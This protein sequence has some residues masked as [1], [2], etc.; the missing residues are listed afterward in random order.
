MPAFTRALALLAFALPLPAQVVINEFVYDDTGVDNREFVEL[1]NA[2]P[3][4]VDISGW[5]LEG[6]DN[7]WTAPLT[8]DN[9][10]DYTIPP[11]T[12]LMPGAF[13]VIGAPTVPNVHLVVGTQDLWENDKE[14]LVLR[15]PGPAFTIVDAVGYEMNLGTALNPSLYEGPGI[16]GN[17]Q[18]IDNVPSSWSR[19]TDGHDT[20]DNGADFGL[21]PIT[22]GASNGFP[23]IVPWCDDFEGR[24]VETT[25]ND[26]HA[27]F[28][29]PVI[30]DPTAPGQ[31]L[32]VPRPP[33]PDGGLCG[34]F[35]DPAGGGNGNTLSTA[36]AV[37]WTV[38]CYVYVRTGIA[39]PGE[40]ETWSIGV[41]GT[42]DP[43]HNTSIDGATLN[44]TITTVNQN[45][46]V[47]WSYITGPALSALH[48][49]DEGSGGPQV[50]LATIPVLPGVNDGWQRLRL[51]VS[52]PAITAHFGGT[53]GDPT[54]GQVFNFA[55]PTTHPGVPYFGYREF[56]NPGV[57]NAQGLLVDRLRITS[58]GAPCVGAFQRNQPGASLDLDGT[59]GGVHTRAVTRK[60]HGAI[61][62]ANLASTAVGQPWDAGISVDPLVPFPASGLATPAGQIVNL[63]LFTP[64]LPLIWLNGGA[65]PSLVGS[66]FPGPVAIPL[67][68]PAANLVFAF[69]MVV[70][71]PANAE[72]ISLSQGCQLEVADTVAVP[73]V[74]GEDR[75]LKVDISG[76]GPLCS[77][78][79]AL[80]GNVY[81]EMYVST[82]GYLSFGGFANNA[83]PSL[84]LVSSGPVRVGCYTDMLVDHRTSSVTVSRPFPGL[85]RVQYTN[86]PMF[87]FIHLVNNYTID[88]DTV[89]GAVTLG[90]LNGLATLGTATL[91]LGISRGAG[92]TNPG[93]AVFGP[94]P[95]AG[96]TA[97]PT[98]MIYTLGPAAPP[99]GVGTL[100]FTPNGFLNYDWV[101]L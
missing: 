40:W 91:F 28:A 24:P 93:P 59:T 13:Y 60:C 34:I 53:F 14:A 64:T 39:A 61:V 55:T 68:A 71:D 29:R 41:R 17:H 98:D 69:Q 94:A 2:G 92:A 72:G 50:V 49:V 10:P 99:P 9:N 85:I 73:G 101:S 76:A 74:V 58:G 78:P 87:G 56:T 83:S 96:I 26:F 70:V 23:V 35:W 65:A 21:R 1:Y 25:V 11:G 37:N 51:S 8:G 79:M 66:A 18:S 86:V 32:T 82:N 46:G 15:M 38:E 5:I 36:A 44:P 47:C 6:A 81:T 3:S 16:W 95:Q 7:A 80:Y 48:L 42:T 57:A 97:N 45:T 62:T 63:D 89:S 20:G 52:G 19:W 67:A 77:G 31:S 100:I 33:S 4:P 27:G 43:F 75:S 22:P 84:P 88:L 12:I 90:G 54:S 30:V